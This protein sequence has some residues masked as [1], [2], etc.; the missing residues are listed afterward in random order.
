MM[1]NLVKRL[2]AG[3]L[4]WLPSTFLGRYVY[5]KIINAAMNQKK[6]VSCR[7]NQMTFTVPN[8]LNQYRISTFSTLDRS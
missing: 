2:I 7:S 5:Q 3:L 1:R 4:S 6:V 8:R